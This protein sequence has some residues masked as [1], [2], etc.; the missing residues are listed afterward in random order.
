MPAIVGR[1]GGGCGVGAG[2][3]DGGGDAVAEVAGLAVEVGAT[4][5][6]WPQL[7]MTTASPKAA[8]R[9]ITSAQES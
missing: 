2:V 4:A 9:R 1:F 5:V 6:G 8:L 3:G 7:T